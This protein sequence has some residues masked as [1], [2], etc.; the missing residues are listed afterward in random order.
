MLDAAWHLGCPEAIPD[1]V[2]M[3][4]LTDDGS[5]SVLERFRR[6]CAPCTRF[7]QQVA[8]APPTGCTTASK[9]VLPSVPKGSMGRDVFLSGDAVEA[10]VLLCMSRV[11]F[12][13]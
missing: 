9:G 11:P 10:F 6:A 3:S 8:L 1:I 4:S 12:L 13:K 2:M 7:W 5:S